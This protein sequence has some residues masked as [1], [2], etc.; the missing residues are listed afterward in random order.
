MTLN[1]SDNSS[2][3]QS[4]AAINDDAARPTHRGQVVR[5]SSLGPAKAE[6][7]ACRTF[8]HSDVEVTGMIETPYPDAEWIW[9]APPQPVVEPTQRRGAYREWIAFGYAQWSS[10]SDPSGLASPQEGGRRTRGIRIRK[11]LRHIDA[12]HVPV[13]KERL[14]GSA[15]AISK[16]FGWSRAM[17]GKLAEL[18]RS[19]PVKVAALFVFILIATRWHHVF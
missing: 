5:C 2:T 18:W 4:I 16:K 1:D 19:A 15:N 7:G 9:I 6:A 11:V 8:I 13:T 3:G 17:S 12:D 14:S 10:P